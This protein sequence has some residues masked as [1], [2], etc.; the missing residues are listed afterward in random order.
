[1]LNQG[2]RQLFLAVSWDLRAYHDT[3]N[4]VLVS[5]CGPLKGAVSAEKALQGSKTEMRE[6]LG[7]MEKIGFPVKGSLIC[8]TG[9]PVIFYKK[10]TEQN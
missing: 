3:P 8:P 6:L 9:K 1:M 7:G 2:L 5:L 4:G 10:E